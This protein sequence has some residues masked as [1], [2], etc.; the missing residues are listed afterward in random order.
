VPVLVFSGQCNPV[1]PNSCGGCATVILPSGWTRWLRGWYRCSKIVGSRAPSQRHIKPM[2]LLPQLGVSQNLLGCVRNHSWGWAKSSV[3]LPTVG[4]DHRPWCRAWG[5]GRTSPRHRPTKH[6]TDRN[7][8]EGQRLTCCCCR[9]RSR[10][11][12]LVSPVVVCFAPSRSLRV[13]RR[14]S[15]SQQVRGGAHI[16]NLNL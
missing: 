14:F 7:R 12:T 8:P 11:S 1:G 15:C 5:R 3:S 9:N 2:L 16:L 6:S 10:I 4:M 13:D